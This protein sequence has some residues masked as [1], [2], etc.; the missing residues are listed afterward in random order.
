MST[1]Q[2]PP[3]EKLPPPMHVRAAW[4][5]K[6]H[7]CSDDVSKFVAAFGRGWV[8]VT[9]VNIEK[10]MRAGIDISWLLF[11][12]KERIV[13]AKSDRRGDRFYHRMAIYAHP[14]Y[15][16]WDDADNRWSDSINWDNYSPFDPPPLGNTY[17]RRQT[18]IRAER[19]IRWLANGAKGLESWVVLS[20]ESLK[21]KEVIRGS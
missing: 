9:A 5:K 20:N 7:A 15:I 21:F 3:A 13:L 16:E 8:P 17:W 6:Q 2:W 4:L 12:M 18:A 10:A 1:Q 19:V 14:F 11:Q